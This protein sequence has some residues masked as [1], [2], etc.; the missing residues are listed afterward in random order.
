MSA[1]GWL[2]RRQLRQQWLSALPVAAIAALGGAGT[3][4][5]LEAAERTSTAYPRYLERAEVGD[6]LINPSLYSAEIDSVIRSLPG[7]R[8]VTSEGIF[9]AAIGDEGTPIRYSEIPPEEN[10]EGVFGSTD[11]RYVDMDR[12]A[13]REGRAP[14]GPAEAVVSVELAAARDIDISDVIPVSFW[15]VRDELRALYLGEDPLMTPIGVEHLT[16]V[17]VATFPGEVLPDGLYPRGRMV[18]SPDVAARYDCLPPEPPPAASAEEAAVLMLPEDCA[19]SYRYWSLAIDGGDRAVEAAQDAFI[20]AAVERNA[21]LAEGLVE[22]DARYI[23]IATTTAQEQ[24]RVQRSTQPTVAALFV[25]GVASGVITV[26]VAG[27]AVARSLRRSATDQLRW[28][29]FGLRVGER[30]RIAIGLPLLAVVAGVAGAAALAWWCSPLGP[31]GSVRAVEP[32]PGNGL[33][34]EA[35]LGAI[36]LLA[37]LMV[38]VTVLAWRSAHVA[39]RADRWGSSVSPAPAFVRAGHPVVAEGLRAAWGTGRGAGL[40][41]ASGATAATAL[42]SALVFGTSLSTLLATPAWYG[43]PWQVA[44]LGGFGYGGVDLERAET[45]LESRADVERWAGLGFWQAVTVDGVAVPSL[46]AFERPSEVDLALVEGRLPIAEDEIALGSRFAAERGIGVGE[47]V[48]LAGDRVL[49][50]RAEVTGLV[51]LPTLGPLQS[52]R[53]TPGYGMLMP[54]SALDADLVKGLFTFV[55]LEVRP[56]A[57]PETVLAELRDDFRA[58]DRFGASL[59]YTAPVRPAEIINVQSMRA[60]PVL[61]GGLVTAAA[62]V[63][64]GTAMVTSVGARRRELGILRSLGFTGRQVRHSVRVQ[65]LAIVLAALAVGIP[66]GLVV[67]RYAWRTFADQLGVVTTPSVPPGAIALTVAGGLVVAILTAVVP[68]QKASRSTPSEVLRRD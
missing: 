38:M 45:T 63:G 5:A 41:V 50:D 27:L 22:M 48:T 64:L 47:E 8:R 40:V 66:L 37:S 2:A 54:A 36:G 30:A 15:P 24:Q 43:W 9:Y 14:T 12:L 49:V 62:A 10:F 44:N 53:A 16:V 11:G 55:G 32:S 4:V 31:V 6:V 67:G 59:G 3:L 33:G 25:L 21:E 26:V 61:V 57:D 19:A 65:A 18:V 39:S 60:V 68:A 51:V 34:A 58:W 17:G 29:Q 7:V 13:Y 35:W 52:D 20:R 42:V 28:W 1:I 56:G 23:L 46:V